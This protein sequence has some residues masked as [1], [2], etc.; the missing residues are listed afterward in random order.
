M[1]EFYKDWGKSKSLNNDGTVPFYRPIS[2]TPE[3]QAQARKNIGVT[4]SPDITNL[5]HK[6]DELEGNVAT[7][8][9]KMDTV[10]GQFTTLSAEA[11]SALDIANSALSSIGSYS[12]DIYTVSAKTDTLSASLSGLSGRV[13]TNETNIAS[14][15]GKNT[16]QDNQISTLSSNVAGLTNS[17]TYHEAKIQ[18]LETEW[19]AYSA[20]EDGRITSAIND[21]PVQV[22]AEVSGQLSGKQNNLTPG[23]NVSLTTAGVIDVKNQNGY[24]TNYSV[25]LGN[26]C[27]AIGIWA[28]AHGYN[29][30]A[31]GTYSYSHAEGAYTSAYGNNSHAEGNRTR[32][33]T[34][35]AH[36]EGSGTSAYGNNS[37]AEGRLVY[38]RGNNSHAEGN[39]TTA[40]GANSH[41]EGSA[42]SAVGLYSHAEG[43]N[44]SAIGEGSLSIGRET[45]A[46]GNYSF[47]H[48]GGYAYGNGSH[49]EG[50]S[51]AYGMLSHAEGY[52]TS[53]IQN[54]SHAEGY[55]T[56]SDNFYSHAEGAST[57]TYGIASHAEGGGTS[58]IKNASH[59]EGQETITDTDYQ[60]V[61][62]KYNA[63]ATGALHVIGNG[64]STANRNNIVET[65]TSGVNV[66]GNLKV[67]GYE[68]VNAI[69]TLGKYMFDNANN[70][71]GKVMFK[72]I[73]PTGPSATLSLYNTYDLG[74]TTLYVATGTAYP[75]ANTIYTTPTGTPGEI[76][77][78][79]G[80]VGQIMSRQYSTNTVNVSA[81]PT[82]NLPHS[83][84][85]N[86]SPKAID[87][88]AFAYGNT[89]LTELPSGW[90]ND[91][92]SISSVNTNDEYIYSVRQ[93]FRGCTNLTGDVKPWMDHVLSQSAAGQAGNSSRAYYRAG[94]FMGC[95]G[96]SAYAT[97]SA[98]PTY[99]GFFT[100]A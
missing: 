11:A 31:S 94:M 67:S 33:N 57:Y 25:A 60:H 92:I 34:D 80:S 27:S 93:M 66:N 38:A 62:G 24:S 35:N 1:A 18:N 29:T 97:L 8:E 85:N 17:A 2:L 99:S 51:K 43:V 53:A 12:A 98:D 6:V 75:Q 50:A 64:T 36:T 84:Y 41:A 59:A 83:V 47:A 4:G 70:A 20:Y 87:Y 42:T 96:V 58:A 78:W 21:L 28:F 74:N 9:G 19:S 39:S 71:N 10:S 72:N 40:Y 68:I 77:A 14:I 81:W 79:E 7:V 32:A 48:G 23:V 16:V 5:E 95:T 100:V 89:Y 88:G 56:K 45:I 65:Y 86:Q 52:S 3:E 22:S 26:S 90:Y 69:E 76:L 44:T 82:E 46:S 73:K 55:A 63:P 61:E 91:F 37:H 30:I 54:G 13:G 15:S 49:A